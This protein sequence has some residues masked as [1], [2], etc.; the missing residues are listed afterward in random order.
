MG[1]YPYNPT[2]PCPTCDDEYIWFA[3]EWLHCG[4]EYEDRCPVVTPGLKYTSKEER[5]KGRR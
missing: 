5:G 3:G 2:K 4:T 1:E